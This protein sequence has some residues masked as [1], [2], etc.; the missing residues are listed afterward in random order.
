MLATAFSILVPPSSELRQNHDGLVTASYI[1][2]WPSSESIEKFQ[3][4]KF[5]NAIRIDVV[6]FSQKMELIDY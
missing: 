5:H 1:T 2:D 3:F 4:Y 6:E